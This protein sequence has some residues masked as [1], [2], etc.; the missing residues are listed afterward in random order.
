MPPHLFLFVFRQVSSF[1]SVYPE[2]LYSPGCLWTQN[3]PPW[4]SLCCYDYRHEPPC[5]VSQFLSPQL[6]EI[7]YIYNLCS[8]HHCFFPEPAHYHK[9]KLYPLK[10]NYPSSPTADN[11]YLT[12]ISVNLQS[13]SIPLS[14]TISSVSFLSGVSHMAYLQGTSMLCYL[15]VWMRNVPHRFLYWTTWSLTGGTLWRGAAA[16]LGEV[17]HGK[18]ALRVQSLILLPV[19]FLCV[20][21][22]VSSQL[23]ALA[24]YCYAIMGP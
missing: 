18:H 22:N 20:G 15:V 14:H 16:F 8:Y 1:S 10:C 13:T 23:P 4:G 24:A 5:L 3:D 17:C 12:C 19:C 7:K 9:E 6:S 2:T 11:I 21:G